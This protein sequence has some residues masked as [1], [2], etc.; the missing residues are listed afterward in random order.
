MAVSMDCG[1]NYMR[2]GKQEHKDEG[3]YSDY[4]IVFTNE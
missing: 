2:L 1:F 4:V 3:L